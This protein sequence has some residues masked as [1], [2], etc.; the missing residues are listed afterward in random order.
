MRLN[1]LAFLRPA[2]LLPLLAMAAAPAPASAKP[3]PAKVDAVDKHR[4]AAKPVSPHPAIWLLADED[5]K[6]YLFGTVHVLPP[7]FQWRSP[8]ID[9]IIAEAD[10]LVEETYEEPGKDS[11]P[12]AHMAMMLAEPSP[13]LARVPP[14]R[15]AALKA[16]IASSR[17]PISYYDRMQTW[18]AGMALGMAQLLGS[19]GTEDSGDAP[20]VEDVMEVEF[21]A[22]GKPISS[23]EDPGAVV[24][25]LNAL[26]AEV[27]LSLLLD[28]ISAPE[29]GKYRQES[30]TD[31]DLL[32]A[33]GRVDALAASFRK[34]F[35]PA[36][37][38]PLLRRR[39]E[40]WSVWLAE[41]LKKPGTILFA[42][43]AAHLAGGDSVQNMLAR[44]G[45]TVTR[46]E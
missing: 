40:A 21:R 22:A 9:R 8:A 10:E 1:L 26:P 38:D 11:H 41:R 42:V 44:R 7:G 16:A 5:T 43:G 31:D 37:L 29:P 46:I 25:S 27:Q 32:W 20:G 30:E 28:T 3:A 33:T 14:D 18:A 23:V 15:R 19:Y 2:W 24:A 35:P 13:I 4:S 45:L 36:L 12:E 39:N 34:D 17:I 6:I